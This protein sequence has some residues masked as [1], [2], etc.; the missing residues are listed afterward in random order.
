MKKILIPLVIYLALL[1]IYSGFSAIEDNSFLFRP[2]W[3]IDHYV[4]ISEQGYIKHP[5]NPGLHYPLGDICGNVGWYPMWPLVVRTFRPVLGNSYQTSF[6]TL[7]YIFGAAGFILMFLLVDRLH[8]F[9][10]AILTVSALAFGPS[11]FYYLTGFP[12]ALILF[13]FVIY[14]HLLYREQDII[15]EIGL[16]ASA[17]MLS[18]SYPSGLLFAVIPLIWYW[19]EKER[20]Y[21][22]INYWLKMARYLVPFALGPLILWTYF[23]I[24][25]DD[26]F[27]QLHFQE[28]YNRNW[29]FPLWTMAKSLINNPI[30]SPENLTMLWYGLIFAAFYPYRIRKELWIFGLVMYFFSP[31]TGS[32]M[33][34]YRHYLIIF[35]VFM[36][37]GASARPAWFKILYIASGIFL[38]LY[39]FFPTFIN[40][41][42]I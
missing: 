9:K 31:A 2:V 15:R 36:I 18:L 35:P 28:K 8:G 38:A 11:A 17:L 23:Y 25:F 12:Y 22:S 41:R 32:M 27:L 30:F 20:D 37:I 14:L 21:K 3:D 42:L 7:A 19:S 4:T 10:T 34:L 29:A 24:E 16:F 40:S 39:I 1:G 26:F 13:L 5:C 6:L 33:S